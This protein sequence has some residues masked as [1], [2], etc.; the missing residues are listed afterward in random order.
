MSHVI[1][2]DSNGRIVYEGLLSSQEIATIDEILNALKTEIPQIEAEL[3][4]VY[5]K[6]VL[7]KYHLGKFLG[8]LLE[9]YEISPSERRK[10]WD[11][12]KDCA[13]KENRIRDDGKNAETRSYYGQCYR[14]SQYDQDVV[15]KLSWRQWQ[16]LFDRVGNREDERIFEW[17]RQR[18]EKIKEAD[19]REFEKGLHLYLKGKDTS[20]FTDEELFGIYESLMQMG[21]FWLKSFAKFKREH[22][23][24]AKIKT[25]AKRSKKY[26]AECLRLKKEKRKSLDEEIFSQ[27]FES[28]MK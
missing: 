25:K 16:D 11:E 15:E 4:A 21:Q 24:S 18:K 2:V 10:F 5:G 7:Y 1:T 8:E 22:P 26:Q 3:E 20:V 28:A 17:I 12:I 27:A 13:T 9:K 19:W 6:S 14:L 23:T